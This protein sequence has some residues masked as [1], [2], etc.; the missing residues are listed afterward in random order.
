MVGIGDVEIVGGVERQTA[1]V[2]TDY[3]HRLLPPCPRRYNYRG[4]KD[5]LAQLEAPKQRLAPL[6]MPSFGAIAGR[7]PAP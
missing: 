3:R 2:G 5:K 6:G 1:G 4:V 7:A